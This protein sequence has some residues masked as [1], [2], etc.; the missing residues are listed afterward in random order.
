MEQPLV[1]VI[2]PA[3][4]AE[5]QLANC[6]D[7]ICAQTWQNLEVIIV[8]D[9]STDKTLAAAEALCAKDS[10]VKVISRKNSGASNARNAGLRLAQGE[11]I[12]F[13]DS[14]DYMPPQAIKSLADAAEA[15]GADLV[16]APYWMV[17]PPDMSLLWTA[18]QNRRK[19][20]G[21]PMLRAEAEERLYGFLP[22]GTYS[23][24]AY[25]LNMLEKPATY[26]YGAVWNKLY[27][28]SMIMEH[29]VK[30]D[31]KIRM[32]EDLAFNIDYLRF[33]R[34]VCAVDTPVYYY[35]QNPGSVV[36]TKLTPDVIIEHKRQI[37]CRY[38]ALFKS[39][40]A[41]TPA[42]KAQ[43]SKFYISISE[44]PYPS[45][46]ISQLVKAAREADKALFAAR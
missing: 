11:Y 38:R 37:Y 17:L 39:M 4:N 22:A 32:A 36:H 23:S 14:D 34:S 3:Y 18:E 2:I 6:V 12:R 26:F 1:S 24:C 29:G 42:V 16:V 40:N 13:A 31:P 27:R 7:S 20:S 5:K 46:P 28:R 8:N 25:A 30:F 10:R 33:A 43:L 19:S 9:G 44:I 41:L 45:H 21:Q 15:S 35:I